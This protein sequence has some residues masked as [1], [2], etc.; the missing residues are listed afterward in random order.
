MKSLVKS[1]RLQG[2]FLLG[3][4]FVSNPIFSADKP[5]AE[6]ILNEAY[7]RLTGA[8]V[9]SLG[10]IRSKARLLG[11]KTVLEILK[12]EVTDGDSEWAI[13]AFRLLSILAS[14]HAAYATGGEY[15]NQMY[16][17]FFSCLSES[18][19]CS[20]DPDSDLEYAVLAS[21][22]R[23][24]AAS[25][26]SA[27][28]LS[29]A[30]FAHYSSYTDFSFRVLREGVDYVGTSSEKMRL[31]LDAFDYA[32]AENAY[33]AEGSGMDEI[34]VKIAEMV[35][36]VEAPQEEV[37]GLV[38][39]AEGLRDAFV[40]CYGWEPADEDPADFIEKFDQALGYEDAAEMSDDS[41]GDDE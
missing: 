18:D 39:R 19:F 12:I 5:S 2:L 41:S 16:T 29:K 26:E 20:A 38:A 32:K 36:E 15:I 30:V 21:A 22:K 31:F 6:E 14:N 28:A 8:D 33:W 4:L 1:T 27:I 25:F 24:F 17:S 35:A 40:A 9:P 37:A 23:L 7:A 11:T 34:L 13:K 3:A 10:A